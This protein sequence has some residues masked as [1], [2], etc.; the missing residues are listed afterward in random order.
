MAALA[1]I[2]FGAS[3]LSEDVAGRRARVPHM[4]TNP[5]PAGPSKVTL[6]SAAS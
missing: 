3:E 2:V 1:A 4:R 6:T 5:A